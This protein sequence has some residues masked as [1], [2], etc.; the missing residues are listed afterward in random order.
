[1]AYVNLAL[2]LSEATA[3][4][5]TPFIWVENALQAMYHLTDL[6]KK[7]VNGLRGV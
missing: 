4:H 6:N 1:M 3:N 7:A 2:S 5:F